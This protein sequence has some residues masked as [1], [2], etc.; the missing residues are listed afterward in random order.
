MAPSGRPWDAVVTGAGFAGLSAACA[1][2]D[3]GARVLVVESRPVAG[4]RAFSYVD[5]ATGTDVDNG[6]HILLG[7]YRETRQ[8]LSRIGAAHAVQLQAGLSVPMVDT[9]GRASEL[10]CPPLP[11]PLHLVAGVLAWDALTWAD[12]MSL[13]GLAA[14]LARARA[15]LSRGATPTDARPDESVRAW[16]ARHGQTSRITTLLWEPLAVAALNQSIDEAAA[17]LF[18]GVLARMFSDDAEDATLVLPAR[19][20]TP[21]YVEPAVAYLQ[22]RGSDVRCGAPARLAVRDGAVVGVRIRDEQLKASCVIA[23]VPWFALPSLVDDADGVRLPPA[24]AATV[25]AAR[26]TPWS[27]I[28]TVN[29][30]FDRPVMDHALIGLP[31]RTFQFVFEKRADGGDGG[32][33]LSLVASGAAAAVDRTNDALVAHALDEIRGA[34]P[35]V[36]SATLV[37]ATAVREKRATFSLAPGVPPRP[38]TDIGVPGLLLAGDWVETGLPATIES[39]VVSGHRAAALAAGR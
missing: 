15:A 17:P 28:V 12:R 2:A 10:R 8:F 9:A 7:C 34:L 29:L 11:A 14:P 36:S 24:W 4:G 3:R 25:D 1:L 6:Q 13:V 18:L 23:A 38:M 32:S 35:R 20:L 39:A 5:R 26:Q 16:L 30:W 31:G 37:R 21:F 27:P 33:Q 19:A 22:G